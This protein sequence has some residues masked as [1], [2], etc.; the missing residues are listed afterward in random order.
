MMQQ[1]HSLHW[2]EIHQ[3]DLSTNTLFKR[4]ISNKL[5]HLRL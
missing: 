3:K 5:Q 1:V 2:A 4:E